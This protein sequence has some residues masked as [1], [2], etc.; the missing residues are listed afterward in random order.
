[1]PTTLEPA[2]RIQAIEFPPNVSTETEA[3]TK[4][5]TLPTSIRNAENAT[6]PIIRAGVTA[7]SGP[8]AK[9]ADAAKAQISPATAMAIYLIPEN[10]VRFK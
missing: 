2:I 8:I 9:L 3:I 10:K 7:K 6:A 4:S 5:I 1:M